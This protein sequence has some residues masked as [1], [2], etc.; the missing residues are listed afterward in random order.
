MQLTLSGFLS[1]VLEEFSNLRR[2]L[3]TRRALSSTPL[4]LSST[5]HPLVLLCCMMG[6][7]VDSLPWSSTISPDIEFFPFNNQFLIS[8]I[9]SGW[10]FSY[11]W[12]TLSC[13]GVH[14]TRGCQ[15]L[16]AALIFSGEVPALGVSRWMLCLQWVGGNR[17]WKGSSSCCV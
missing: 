11:N 2:S 9:S 16:L 1:A 17:M 5:F 4:S 6:K 14:H 10:G 13:V 7:W 12:N 3:F 8:A 15:Q